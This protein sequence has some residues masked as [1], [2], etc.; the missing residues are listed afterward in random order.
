MKRAQI[1]S[2]SIDCRLRPDLLAS[3]ANIIQARLPSQLVTVNPEF[4]LEA[5]TNRAFRTALGDAE[6]STADGKGIQ[7]AAYYNSLSFPTWQPARLVVGL[8]AGAWV[9]LIFILQSKELNHPIPEIITGVDLIDQLAAYGTKH[10]W[11]FFFLGGDKGIAEQAA[12]KLRT[13]YPELIVVGAEAGVAKSVQGKRRKDELNLLAHRIRALK[14]DILLVALGAPTQDLFI[15]E[16]KKILGISL[17]LGVGGAFD[18]LA[19]IVPRAPAWLRSLGLEWCWRLLIQP[20]RWRRILKATL[21]F[22]WKV[23]WARQYKNS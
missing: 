16:H 7:L 2:V 19:G 5:Q 20:W 8:L 13:H 3:C 18:Y 23:F 22:P 12:I 15:H 21:V 1:L 4:I 6:M 10:R 14:P 9:G 17:M 11:K